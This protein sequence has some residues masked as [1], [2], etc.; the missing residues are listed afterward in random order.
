MPSA[1]STVVAAG[2]LARRYWELDR[3]QWS[4]EEDLLA[5]QPG[6]LREALGSAAANTAFYAELF[7]AGAFDPS[8]VTS[9]ADLAHLPVATKRR[10][11][12]APLEQRLVRGADPSR[13]V[14][15]H[16]SGSTAEPFCVCLSQAE[17]DAR[18][19]AE[20]RTFRANGIGAR[21]RVL[22][23]RRMHDV[24]GEPNPM[25]YMGFFPRHFAPF[26]SSHADKLAAIE[27]VQPHGL[28]AH[29][30]TLVPLAEVLR[31]GG[32]RPP[33]SLRC[34][35]S[36]SEYLDAPA[37]RNIEAAFSVPVI[38]HYGTVEFG[39]LAWECP[40]QD[41]LHLNV[42]DFVF[43]IVDEA[44]A[45]VAGDGGGELL[46]TALRQRTMPLIRYSTGDRAQWLRGP[47]ACGR[48]LPRIRLL[49]GRTMDYLVRPDGSFVNPH[50]FT[51]AWE[52][53]EGIVQFQVIQE[54]RD[55]LV[56]RF[57]PAAGTDPARA[58][59]ELRRRINAEFGPDM[60]VLFERVDEI[61]REV[62]GKLK[63][64]H[65]KVAG[66]VTATTE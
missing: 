18:V 14:R 61:P 35:F 12:A 1:L 66:A 20:I 23:F 45:P 42:E 4:G 59:E 38:D 29:P 50:F 46:V 48:G 7:R 52:G 54:A 36:C 40:R 56:Y 11:L 8:G 51:I 63:Y 15:R 44:G 24:E 33:R 17:K 10:L 28:K 26:M 27:A 39:F 2:R 53:V 30:S 5:R 6:L 34:I 47:C 9:L 19:L 55:L 13:L 3:S 22:A 60:R 31:A 62:S 57:I 16:T 37:R 49:R 41:G 65:S 43:E 21:D 25:T 64:V 58:E 32:M